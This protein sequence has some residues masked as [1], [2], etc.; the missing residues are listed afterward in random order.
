[1][2][3]RS[4]NSHGF[5]PRSRKPTTNDPSPTTALIHGVVLGHNPFAVFQLQGYGEQ[6]LVRTLL[7]GSV[8]AFAAIAQQAQW[9]RVFPVHHFPGDQGMAGF[10]VADEGGVLL[11][12][13]FRPAGELLLAVSVAHA[14][15]ELG[16]LPLGSAVTQR[17]ERNGVWH[18]R[19]RVAVL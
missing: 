17:I 11:A 15:D 6:F 13:V 18:A 14:A 3:R 2:V 19:E 5:E 16:R 12:I 10:R 4:G 9:R 1:M 7:I 8:A